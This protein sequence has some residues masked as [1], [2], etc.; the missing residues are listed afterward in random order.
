MFYYA[1]RFSF[2]SLNSCDRSTRHAILL[3]KKVRLADQKAMFC[4][5]KGHVLP[6]KY[7]LL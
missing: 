5:R 7:A 2:L 6:R 1:I 4:T 3:T